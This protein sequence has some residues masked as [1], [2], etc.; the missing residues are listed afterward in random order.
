M[1]PFKGELIE[2]SEGT[3]TEE[4]I[5][6]LMWY[7]ESLRKEPGLPQAKKAEF[8]KVLR[9]LTKHKKLEK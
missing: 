2:L 7:F 6:T 4:G 5:R 1:K 9:T 3:L 8:E